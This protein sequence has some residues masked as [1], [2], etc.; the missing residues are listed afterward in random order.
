MKMYYLAGLRGGRGALMG[1]DRAVFDV[2]VRLVRACVCV[3][4]CV[5][6]IACGSCMA[7][8]PYHT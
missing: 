1:C 5:C 3:C 7:V 2:C 8:T 4:V 6:A